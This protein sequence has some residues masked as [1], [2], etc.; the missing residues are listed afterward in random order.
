MRDPPTWTRLCYP[1]TQT[2][3]AIATHSCCCSSSGASEILR[4]GLRGDSTGLCMHGAH[5]ISRNCWGV[6]PGWWKM[7][8]QVHWELQSTIQP[9]IHDQSVVLRTH[10]GFRTLHQFKVKEGMCGKVLRK[11]IPIGQPRFS[12]FQIS[13]QWSGE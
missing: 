8:L 9:S 11:R 12:F 10:F 5:R 4:S 2:L 13:V 7:R 6:A 1:D 3:H